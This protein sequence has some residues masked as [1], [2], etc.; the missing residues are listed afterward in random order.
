MGRQDTAGNVVYRQ[1][2]WTRIA[3]WTWAVCLFFLAT[4]GLQILSAHSALYVGEQSGFAFDNAVLRIGAIRDET[5]TGHLEVFGRR[6][7][8]TGLLGVSGEQVQPFPAWIT[9]SS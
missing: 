4:S 8:T 1:S 7:E 6:F 3:H 2:V 9:G 5:V